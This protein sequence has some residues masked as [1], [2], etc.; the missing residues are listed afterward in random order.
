M[1]LDKKD[2]LQKEANDETFSIDTT[3]KRKY[4]EMQELPTKDTTVIL[5]ILC[6]P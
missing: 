1:K 3:Y 5:W 6:V 2:M 4:D